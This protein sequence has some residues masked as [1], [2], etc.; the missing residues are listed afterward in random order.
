M[1][2]SYVVEGLRRAASGDDRP[3]AENRRRCAV[4]VTSTAVKRD[5]PEVVAALERASPWCAARKCWPS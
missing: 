5:N 1:A 2:E 4:V 3:A